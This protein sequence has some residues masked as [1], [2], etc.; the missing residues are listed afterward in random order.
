[1]IQLEYKHTFFRLPKRVD[2]QLPEAGWDFVADLSS[3]SLFVC[4]GC[5]T[6]R[7]NERCSGNN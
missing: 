4:K 6:A 3:L 5:V 2:H 1:M 7:V